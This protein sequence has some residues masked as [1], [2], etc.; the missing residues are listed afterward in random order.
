MDWHSGLNSSWHSFGPDL[1]LGLISTVATRVVVSVNICGR[2][3]R[4]GD[5]AA[6]GGVAHR[7]MSNRKLEEMHEG[8]VEVEISVV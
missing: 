1:N 2:G 7:A 3:S 6:S 4:R 8:K 5:D